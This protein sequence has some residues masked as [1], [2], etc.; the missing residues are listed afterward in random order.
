MM[1]FLSKMSIFRVKKSR[2]LVLQNRDDF[3]PFNQIT[4]NLI[5]AQSRHIG[6]G[7]MQVGLGFG[8]EFSEGIRL[9]LKPVLRVGI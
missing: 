5:Q 1:A 7:S 2:G 9:G 8:P 6:R 4:Q 3:I